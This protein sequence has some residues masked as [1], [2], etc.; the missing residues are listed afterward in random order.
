MISQAANS[1]SRAIDPRFNP[2]INVCWARGTKGQL[3][4]SVTGGASA[5]VGKSSKYVAVSFTNYTQ[6]FPSIFVPFR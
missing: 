3:V 4:I 5:T 1:L 6:L 2:S